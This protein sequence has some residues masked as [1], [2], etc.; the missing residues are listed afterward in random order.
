MRRRCIDIED[1]RYAMVEARCKRVHVQA[2][3]YGVLESRCKCV[4]VKAWSSGAEV[5]LLCSRGGID[6]WRR[7][8]GV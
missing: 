6:V 3:R 7:A 8:S 2:R 1:A 5:L 4:D